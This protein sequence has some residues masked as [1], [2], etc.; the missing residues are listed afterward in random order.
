MT[1]NKHNQ[2]KNSI[3]D[4]VSNT[5]A[6]NI[7]HNANNNVRETQ[8][9]K[10]KNDVRK[11]KLAAKMLQKSFAKTVGIGD[12]EGLGA[13]DIPYCIQN[14]RVYNELGMDLIEDFFKNK[15]ILKYKNFKMLD[16]P[17]P[18]FK[19]YTLKINFVDKKIIK[20]KND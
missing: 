12:F 7:S 3:T 11:D 16:L 1:K 8:S 20:N 17:H 19:A 18:H 2:V 6:K 13:V 5:K 10:P 4:K 9:L 14:K 15:I